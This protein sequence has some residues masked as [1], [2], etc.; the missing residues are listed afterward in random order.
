MTAP[1]LSVELQR[2]LRGFPFSKTEDTRT[3]FARVQ[4]SSTAT[5]EAIYLFCDDPN[6]IYSTVPAAPHLNHDQ[7][8]QVALALLA[9]ANN[10]DTFTGDRASIPARTIL[11]AESWHQYQAAGEEPHLIPEHELQLS[12]DAQADDF[13]D[14]NSL[15]LYEK[16]AWAQI[17]A[18]VHD[19]ARRRKALQVSLQLDC[20]KALRV[21]S[22]LQLDCDEIEV[23]EGCSDPVTF[24]HAFAAGWAAAATEA[25]KDLFATPEVK[26]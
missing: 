13:N 10:F 8:R 18:A 12:W 5:E 15:D 11:E 9:F 19:R 4:R 1:S 23:P 20:S 22:S 25:T 3:C 16:L 14:W 21:L 6:G 7:A 2:T 26:S 24:R 17:R